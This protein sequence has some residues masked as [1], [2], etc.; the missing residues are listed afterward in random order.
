[1]DKDQV[2]KQKKDV[3]IQIEIESEVS[4]RS[5]A[6]SGNQEDLE[7]FVYGMAKKDAM[8]NQS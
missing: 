6:L 7:V 8:I 4:I 3:D 1:M 2:D 5:F